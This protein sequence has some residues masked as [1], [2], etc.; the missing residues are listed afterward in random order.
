MSDNARRLMI[1]GL[2][3]AC[4][5]VLDA[6]VARGCMPALE[7]L[8]AGG[9]RGRL[10]SIV[11]CNSAAAW[12]SFATGK[13][14]ARHGVFEFRHSSTA[15]DQRRRV[16][17]AASMRAEA[18]W[19]VLNRKGYRTAVLNVP[20]IT[21][22]VSELDGFMVSGML[23]PRLDEG[24]AFPARV[25]E[26]ILER[27]GGNYAI[28]VPWRLFKNRP[29]ALMK[30]LNEVTAQRIEILSGLLEEEEWDVACVVLESPD[31]LQHCMWRYMDPRHPRYSADAASA[32]LPLVEEHFRQID[33]AIARLRSTLSPGAGLVLMSDH[34]FRSSEWQ[35]LLNRWLEEQGYLKTARQGRLRSKLLGWD[36]PLFLRLRRKVSRLVS[37]E[38]RTRVARRPAIDWTRTLAYCPWDHQ[39]AIRLNLAGREPGGVVDPREREGMLRDLTSRLHAW[40]NPRTGEKVVDEVIP[41]SE[42]YGVEDDAIPDLVFLSSAGHRAAPPL[43]ETSR[44]CASTGW[45]SG[46]HDLEGIVLACGGPFAAGGRE[47]EANLV[48]LF[49]TALFALGE[50]IPDDL[51]GIVREALFAREFLAERA[52]AFETAMVGGGAGRETVL[53]SEDEAKLTESL[54]N[55]GYLE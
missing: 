51:D 8:S 37:D 54:R 46:D 1:L 43:D 47:V 14:P 24:F 31:R 33:V 15:A 9:T 36:H 22:P 29:A 40:R 3:G 34:G 23:T 10:R 28:D 30:H 7:E 18:L 53:S 26:R 11:P 52:V 44:Q 49:P 21:Y 19:D 32:Y 13:N 48:D 50:R 12:A 35:I 6:M 45:A 27:T 38:L 42:L 5:P 20:A 16:V 55:L 2:D 4:W 39:Q 25:R 17:T 41:G